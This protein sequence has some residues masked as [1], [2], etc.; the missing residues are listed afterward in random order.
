MQKNDHDPNNTPSKLGKFRRIAGP[1]SFSTILPLNIYTSIREMAKF[2]W[3]WPIIGGFIGILVGLFG[4]PLLDILDVN[5]LVAAA[6]IY[7]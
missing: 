2:T 7:S 1:V 3:V 5:Q 4:F 6:L